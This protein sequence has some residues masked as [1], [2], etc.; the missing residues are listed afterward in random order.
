MC[1][2]IGY[3]STGQGENEGEDA[4]ASATGGGRALP[5]LVDGLRNLEY[6]GYDS[7]GIAV[8]NGTGLKIQKRE[9]KVSQLR[10]A[11]SENRIEG[12]LAPLVSGALEAS[13][14]IAPRCVLVADRD[15]STLAREAGW[16]VTERFERRVHRSLVRHVHV[17]A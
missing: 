1:G 6:R 2:I 17:L 7:A 13:H 12:E 11:V 16:T 15:W 8:K 4:E 5:V 9:G 3:V 10:N 14:R